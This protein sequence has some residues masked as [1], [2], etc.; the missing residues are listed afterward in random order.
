MVGP[1]AGDEPGVA[2][3]DGVTPD[4]DGAAGEGFDTAVTDWPQAV[5]THN[6]A[7]RPSRFIPRE[8]SRC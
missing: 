3:D 5:R 6:S 8:R 7:A 1:L 2:S 4:I